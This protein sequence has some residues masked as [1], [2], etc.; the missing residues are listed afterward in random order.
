MTRRVRLA[1]Y[2]H[3]TGLKS[4]HPIFPSIFLF[5]KEEE[6]NFLKSFPFEDSLKYFIQACVAGVMYEHQLFMDVD[7]LFL[8]ISDWNK[9]VMEGQ[10]C[11]S[12]IHNQMDFLQKETKQQSATVCF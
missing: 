1:S 4:F 2:D 11:M 9:H 6:N 5:Y 7:H 8:S 3:F 12:M 10:K